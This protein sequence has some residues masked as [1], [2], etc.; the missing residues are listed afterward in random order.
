M[1][2]PS[3]PWSD[4]QIAAL[5][6]WADPQT[7]ADG[8]DARMMRL[9][10]LIVGRLYSPERSD[11]IISA[12]ISISPPPAISSKV[13][14]KNIKGVVAAD[15]KRMRNRSR[16]RLRRWYN[17]YQVAVALDVGHPLFWCLSKHVFT[18]VYM[19][20]DFDISSNIDGTFSLLDVI[21]EQRRISLQE[22]LPSDSTAQV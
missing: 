7:S 21:G 10:Q 17:A 8:V 14:K 3:K 13:S 12:I 5:A 4:S 15:I 11:N 20:M 19:G 9:A 16:H 2:D 18:V 6:V 1:L 22:T